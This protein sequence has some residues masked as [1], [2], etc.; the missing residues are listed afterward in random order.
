MTNEGGLLTLTTGQRQQLRIAIWIAATAFAAGVVSGGPL[1][2]MVVP[3]S[4]S[5]VAVRNAE[6]EVAGAR[7]HQM[8]MRKTIDDLR[9]QVAGFKKQGLQA[10]P[11]RLPRGEHRRAAGVLFRGVPHAA[12]EKT[13][14]IPENPAFDD[15]LTVGY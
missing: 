12:F 10:E 7:E 2:T 13:L 3:E 9:I 1:A 14:E 6:T 15:Y 8:Q 11:A 4:A 5:I